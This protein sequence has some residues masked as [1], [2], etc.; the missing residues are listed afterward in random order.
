MPASLPFRCA[1]CGAQTATSP[2]AACGSSPLLGSYRLLAEI[3][4]SPVG[5]TWQGEHVQTGQ[6]VAIKELPWRMGE[7]RRHRERLLREAQVLQQLDHPSIPAYIE[8]FIA[9]Q[10]RHRVLCIVVDYIAGHTLQEEARTHRSSVE[11]VLDICEALLEILLYLH[12]RSPAVIHRDIKPANV[13]RRPDGSLVLIDFGAVQDALSD[14]DL[15]GSTFS[16]TFGYMAPEQLRGEATP[17]T[18]LY[19]LGALAVALL[20]RREPHTLLD[21]RYQLTWKGLALPPRVDALLHA[22]LQPEA[23]ERP[24]SARAAL[25]L[26]RAARAQPAAVAAAITAPPLP[27]ELERTLRR[28]LREELTE[29]LAQAAERPPIAASAQPALAPSAPPPSTPPL[30][31]P[32]PSTLSLSSPA[33]LAGPALRR[34]W[35]QPRPLTEAQ[36]RQPPH[37]APLILASAVL[38]GLTAVII[39][40]ILAA[41]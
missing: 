22:L 16:G 39:Q 20:T 33:D 32:P 40:L 14:P 21:H 17:A 5:V 15:G 41:L 6:V 37:P 36:R 35:W 27:A 11:E 30:S 7:E 29:Q 13:V 24:P 10:G 28:I 31:T 9:P 38:V 34:G 25:S 2:C 1:T 26:L 4:R 18:D 8:H 3:G 12:S 19:G 23:R